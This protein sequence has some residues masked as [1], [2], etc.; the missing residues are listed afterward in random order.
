MNTTIIIC[1]VGLA[2]LIL[3]ALPSQEVLDE[4]RKEKKK[5]R[6]G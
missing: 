2:I 5:E 4:E 3:L 6:K 1:L